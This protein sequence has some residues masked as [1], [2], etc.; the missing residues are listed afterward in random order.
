MKNFFSFNKNQVV[1]LV[2][3]LFVL[4]LGGLYFFIYVPNNQ[5]H[6]EEQR[7][8][9]LRNIENN[10]HAKVNNSIALLNTLLVTYEKNLPQYDSSKLNSYIK[11]YPRQNFILLPV[12]HV[13][14]GKNNGALSD[15]ASNINLNKK[16]LIIYL[17]KGK[18]QVGLKYSINQFIDQLLIREIFDEY[19]LLKDGKIIYQS[20]PSGIT[21][22]TADSLKTEKS[23]F[24]KNQVKSIKMSGI[25]YKLFAQQLS[26]NEDSAL[27]ITGLV[28]NSN[29]A[30][31]RTKLPENIV[32][33]LLISAMAVI[34]ALPWIKLYQMGNQ[35]RLTVMDG[36][37][38]FAVSML[39]MSLLFFAFFKYNILFRPFMSHSEEV[40]KN[41]ADKIEKNFTAELNDTYQ[42][43]HKLDDIRNKAKLA[44]DLKNLGKS[45]AAK[46]DSNNVSVN[47]TYN[48]T[49]DSIF[50]VLDI[51]KV[52]W[53]RSNGLEVNNWSSS[54]DNAP[55]GDFGRRNYFKHIV[56]NKP[57]FLNNKLD[58]PYYADQIISWTNGKFTSVLSMPSV[59]KDVAV[60]AITFNL[61]CLNQPVFPKGLFYCI[62]NAQGKVLYHSDT[63]KNLNENLLNEISAEQKLNRLIIS[64]GSDFFE[65][66]YSGKNYNFY[67]KPV[68]FL[69]YYVV[70]FEDGTFKSMRDIKIFSFSFYML[71]GFFL[72]LIIQL[73]LIF[74]VCR[75]QSFFEKQYFDISWVRPD[76]RFHHQYN[77]AIV[78]NVINILLLIIFYKFTSFLQFLFI[79]LFSA[80]AVTLFLNILYSKIYKKFEPQRY[81]E[82]KKGNIALLLTIGFINFIAVIM[83]QEQFLLFFFFEMLLLVL[84]W[85][86]LKVAIKLFRYLRQLKEK[87]PGDFWDFSTS[88]SLMIFTRLI[89]TSGI[90]VALFY[91]SSYNF[92]ERLTS[93]YR[94]A[95][96]IQDVLKKAPL[97]DSVSLFKRTNIYNDGVWIKTMSIES[98]IPKIQ[99]SSVAEV[100]TIWL[101]NNISYDIFDKTAVNE[102]YNNRPGSSLF[103]N[104]LFDAKP[105]YTFY[106]LPS[107]K[108]LKLSSFNFNY[109]LPRLFPLNNYGIIYWL[110]FITALFVF[111]RILHLIIRKLFAL[112]LPNEA[113]WQEID[114]LLLTHP[115][116]NS[117][118]F[119]IGS[120]GSGKLEKVKK[121]ISN[122]KIIG[123]DG[124][125]VT[126]NEQNNTAGTVLIVDMILIP[127]NEED[128]KTSKDWDDVK[129]L[130]LNG[131]FSLIIVNHFEYDIQNPLTNLIK[132]N[133]LEGLLQKNRSKIFIISTVHPVNF[134]ESLNEQTIY[135]A[136]NIRK[137]E[138][139]LERWHVL[140]G[141]FKIV[142]EVLSSGNSVI[143]E[144][145]KLWEKTLLMETSNTHFL[146]KMQDPLV[147]MLEKLDADKPDRLDGDS[148]AFKMQVTAHYF[149]MYIWQSL[150]KEEKF[151]LY[152]LAEDSLVNSYDDY[153]LTM[154]VSKG[155]IIRKNGV[156]HL[157]NKGFRN[158]ILT[159]IGTSEAMMIRKQIKDNGN[160]NK[161][162][163]P[164]MILIVAVLAFLF[165]SQQETYS[166]VITYV[167]VLTAA[168]PAVLKFI[169]LFDSNSQ[170]TG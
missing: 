34:L 13:V 25:E 76:S 105:G 39:L 3:L 164:L 38:S 19:I 10:I 31:E 12:E 94:H 103:F 85:T 110:I 35:D 162:K 62:I 9:C 106:T 18:Y 136:D 6:L 68:Q 28:T 66:K 119:I 163:T 46:T 113:G 122:K 16:E 158:F 167:G 20:F 14:P 41:L 60:A 40:K 133:F 109:I 102:F 147:Q 157:F 44:F 82:K 29:Y 151:L 32:L 75:K 71:T 150:T 8:R 107:G 79:L 37:F 144:D 152:D 77:L 118:L 5:Q 97:P 160:W 121:L 140:L 98:K 135:Q 80:M 99:P 100:K 149:Y 81:S 24:L 114:Q 126:L 52:Y 90:P 137:P 73:L 153:N 45:H 139:D 123:K 131:D 47:T 2:T 11:E 17:R 93:R 59:N 87:L 86:L 92:Q 23:A 88:Y 148:L 101:F 65:A 161:L 48:K 74:V 78:L 96:F 145:L 70:I 134:L 43:L 170:K 127:D 120:P 95:L 130:A 156:L 124:N 55:P 89:I 36:M 64:Q 146:N 57:Y 168:L 26:L 138:H 33:L 51:N 1:V 166:T 111:W 53:V 83:I 142:I 50:S 91:T 112:N 104:R 155:L 30:Y 15:S 69:P 58:K 61:K 42:Q 165:A 54:F 108:Y 7:F 141:H 4:T 128:V 169:N 84:S 125:I 72:I 21:A 49:I 63:T 56:D 143:S 115:K 117:L 154:L 129:Q 22:I 116:L 159:A 27:T 67:A 132:L